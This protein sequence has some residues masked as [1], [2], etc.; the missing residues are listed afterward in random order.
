MRPAD[1]LRTTAFRWVFTCTAIFALGLA[2]FATLI[3]RETAGYLTRR[4]NEQLQ[5]S[6]Y[7]ISQGPLEDQL[8]DVGEYLAADRGQF[9]VAALF[10]ARARALAGNLRSLPAGLLP[11]RIV[12]V[13]LP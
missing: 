6:A 7:T 8:E 4:V 13:S 5:A 12:E 9:K 10:D 3:Y 2:L 11:G 1:L